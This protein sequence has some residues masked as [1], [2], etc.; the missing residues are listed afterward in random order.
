[1]L[2]HADAKSAET[3]RAKAK[4]VVFIIDDDSDVREGL[5]A[6]LQSVSLDCEAFS[7]TSDFLQHKRPDT[8]SC[9][10]LD[11]RLPGL[12]GLDFQRELATLPGEYAAPRGCLLLGEELLD[13]VRE[14]HQVRGDPCVGAARRRQCDRNPAIH[15]GP[16]LRIPG[17]HLGRP[18]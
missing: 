7:S 18:G 9:L 5:R 12:S 15:L 3:K 13:D 14:V 1:M 10:V 6:L 2:G 16:D 8:V 11:V 4:P 17:P